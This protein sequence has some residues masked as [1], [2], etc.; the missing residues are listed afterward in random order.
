MDIDGLAAIVTRLIEQGQALTSV[1]QEMA[2]AAAKT[3]ALVGRIVDNELVLV[4]A[5]MTRIL[6]VLWSLVAMA[7]A[8]ALSALA[9]I[10]IMMLHR[11]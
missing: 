6:T 8:A 9:G 3:E 1:H 7:G 11:K 5:E 2:V 10:V 4:Q